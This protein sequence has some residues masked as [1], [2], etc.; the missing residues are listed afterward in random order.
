VIYADE[1]DLMQKG[2]NAT[3]ENANRS[4]GIIEKYITNNFLLTSNNV[5]AE[6]KSTGLYFSI[7]AFKDKNSSGHM[8]SCSRMLN[9]FDVENAGKIAGEVARLAENPIEGKAGRYNIIF[10]YMPMAALLNNIMDSASIFEVESGL[11]F[12]ANKLNKKVGNFNLIDDATLENG[13]N[14]SRFDDEGMPTQKNYV[15]K[16]GILKTYLHNTSTAKRY[17]VK[18]TANAGLIS[19]SAFNIILE[20]RKGD[21]FD[22]KKGLYVTNIWY[23]RFQ[24]HLTG[25]FST[26]PRD[27]IFLIENGEVTKSIK[28]IRISDNFIN[29]MKNI[30]IVGKE[31]KQLK[32]WEAE[33]P[34]VTPEVLIKNVNV[35][36]ANL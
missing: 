10:S 34:V 19:P 8:N 25:D 13:F 29:L 31:N 12:L 24:N 2:I 36:K 26:I 11:S 28:N 15:I 3:L 4:D 16:N 30:S 33:T 32:S 27:G 22:I 7:R 21:I 18:S 14:S 9:K 20:G 23:T 6:D 35:T 1:V 5:E 17:N